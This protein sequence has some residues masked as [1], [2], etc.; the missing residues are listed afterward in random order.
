MF[1]LICARIK[2]WVN[3]R[4][5]GDF[6]RYRGHYD[7]TVMNIS[8]DWPV[9]SSVC[10]ALIQRIGVMEHSQSEINQL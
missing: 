8:N 10:D 3:N 7:V 2:G 5:A 9:W 6:R 1:T 4:E